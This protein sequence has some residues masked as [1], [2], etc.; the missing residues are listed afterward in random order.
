MFYFQASLTSSLSLHTYTYPVPSGHREKGCLT[1]AEKKQS[2]K[3]TSDLSESSMDERSGKNKII[4][5]Q[6]LR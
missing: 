2:L 1:L 6:S 4:I 5:P 3:A